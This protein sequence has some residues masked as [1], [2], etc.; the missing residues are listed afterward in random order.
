[1]SL[2][3]RRNPY[4]LSFYEIY[5]DNPKNY[6]ESIFFFH[7]FNTLCRFF[8]SSGKIPRAKKQIF[9]IFYNV[10]KHYKKTDPFGVYY[11]LFQALRP[12]VFLTSKRISGTVYK[13]P[14]RMTIFKS[15]N[16]CFHT[17]KKIVKQK[18]KKSIFPVILSE[19]KFLIRQPK[20]N[21]LKKKKN[22]VHRLAYINYSYAR[23][24]KSFLCFCQIFFLKTQNEQVEVL[25]VFLFVIAEAV[26]HQD[27]MCP[28]TFLILNFL[29][30]FL[31]VF[32][33]FHQFKKQST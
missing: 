14:T 26:F 22:E 12:R 16:I 31:N 23:R 30:I 9:H 28:L 21:D 25:V 29:L 20:F 8:G 4:R 10:Y 3:F 2:R 32:V 17:F 6:N 15:F 7:F 5:R 33:F 27:L 13:I 19:I 18:K 24:L 1:M 11:R